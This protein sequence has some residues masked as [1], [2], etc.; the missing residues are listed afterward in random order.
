[1]TWDKLVEI[2]LDEREAFIRQRVYDEAQFWATAPEDP[3]AVIG[4][5]FLRTRT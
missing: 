1:M 2:D 5:Y 3:E 4:T